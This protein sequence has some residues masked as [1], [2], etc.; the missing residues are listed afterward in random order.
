MYRQRKRDLNLK[1]NRQLD[2][3]SSRGMI[4]ENEELRMRTIAICEDVDKGQNDIK[5]LRKENDHLKREIWGLRD[6]CEKLEEMLKRVCISANIP[7]IQLESSSNKTD[8]DEDEEDDDED[9]DDE[10]EQVGRRSKGRGRRRESGTSVT[11]YDSEVGSS[12]HSMFA[13]EED[14]RSEDIAFAADDASSVINQPGVCTEDGNDVVYVTTEALVEPQSS[15]SKISVFDR[16]HP[17]WGHAAVVPDLEA[18]REETESNIISAL[19]SPVTTSQFDMFT[20]DACLTTTDNFDNLPDPNTI[21][22][23]GG[24]GVRHPMIQIT[25]ASSPPPVSNDESQQ[26]P[27]QFPDVS[28]VPPTDP[29]STT[30]ESVYS[31]GCVTVVPKTFKVTSEIVVSENQKQTE[32]GQGGELNSS[33]LA[34]TI[35]STRPAIVVQSKSVEFSKRHLPKKQDSDPTFTS[36]ST[37]IPSEHVVLSHSQNGGLG[38]HRRSCYLP[39]PGFSST[40][41]RNFGMLGCCCSDLL[42]GYQSEPSLNSSAACA[43]ASGG[44]ASVE[45]SHSTKF[46]NALCCRI[47]VGPVVQPPPVTLR[48][49]WN[50]VDKN[51]VI[52]FYDGSSV[53][54]KGEEPKV[55]QVIDELEAQFDPTLENILGIRLIPGRIFISLKNSSLVQSFLLHFKDGLIFRRGNNRNLCIHFIEGTAKWSTLILSGIPQELSDLAVISALN[56]FGQVVAPLER[57]NYKGVDISERIAKMHLVINESNVPEFVNVS[58]YNVRIR[59]ETQAEQANGS[60]SNK[61]LKHGQGENPSGN[62]S[63]KQQ[64]TPAKCGFVTPSQNPT[65]SSNVPKQSAPVPITTTT[66][67]SETSSSTLKP[68]KPVIRSSSS[69]PR[70]ETPAT[71]T[72]SPLPT[73]EAKRQASVCVAN[74]PGDQHP[75]KL[76]DGRSGGS[77]HQKQQQQVTIASPSS[78]YLQ[79]QQQQAQTQSQTSSTP[80]LQPPPKKPLARLLVSS[81][82]SFTPV[83]GSPTS[84]DT[85]GPPG[86][87]TGGG[88]GGVL[89][90]F[91]R[92]FD[93]R[94][95]SAGTTS[96]GPLTPCSSYSPKG[97]RKSSVAF[98]SGRPGG[99]R[100][101]K[102]PLPWCGCWGLG[103][104]LDSVK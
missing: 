6:E 52:G 78:S 37:E 33:A 23:Q 86:A 41:H 38:C 15:T 104:G 26:Q 1:P 57:R 58:G 97:R 77:L 72:L 95:G 32:E 50:T 91:Y 28:P 59:V 99:K 53:A 56:Q 49:V 64:Q 2:K 22:I 12:M 102:E 82:G 10:E 103:C 14:G 75:N 8:D 29:N 11:T 3:R 92:N 43:A 44:F 85:A 62:V 55:Q 90:A 73:V 76:L 67:A 96:H 80:N 24:D 61:L 35:N 71:G 63:L 20:T 89:K 70:L 17:A 98:A 84:P 18:V 94:R 13:D 79:A 68:H 101:P 54:G 88:G 19:N 25:P 66:G 21:A 60:D 65:P 100:E 34:A 93:L 45:E 87:S 7:Q 40:V 69:A 47:P 83:L 27:P 4:Y 51:I 31:M 9:E 39:A 36:K 42:S 74:I 16:P 30:Q 81:P 48:S 46:F 5:K